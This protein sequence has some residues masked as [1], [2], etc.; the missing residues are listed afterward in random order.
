MSNMLNFDP[1]VHTND[2]LCFVNI[3]VILSG[4][5]NRGVTRGK[6]LNS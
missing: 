4:I 3:I 6:F 1:A 5:F 2:V